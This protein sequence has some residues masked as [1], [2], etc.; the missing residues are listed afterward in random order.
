MLKLSFIQIV[1]Q[2][3]IAHANCISIEVDDS[4]LTTLAIKY[5]SN[6]IIKQ[7]NILYAINVLVYLV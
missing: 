6:C 4:P 1:I 2:A 7:V 5:I 3:N